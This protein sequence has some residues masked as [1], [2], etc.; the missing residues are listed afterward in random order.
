MKNKREEYKTPVFF[1]SDDGLGALNYLGS[2]FHK[3]DFVYVRNKEDELYTIGQLVIIGSAS[4]VAIFEYER[5][6]VEK[7][8]DEV[9][10]AFRFAVN[11]YLSF[12]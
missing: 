1:R 12:Y 8:Y 2:V 5:C 9:F 11:I 6:E 10:S 7:P 3:N 4:T